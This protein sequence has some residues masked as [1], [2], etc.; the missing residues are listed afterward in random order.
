MLARIRQPLLI[1]VALSLLG[2]V[3]A[4]SQVA[5]AETVNFDPY[6][7]TW[8]RTDK[9]VSDSVVSRTWM[10]G[11]QATAYLT[12]EPYADSP[13]GERTVVYFD[14]SRMEVT[15]PYGDRSDPW[16]VTNGLLVVELVSGRL[17]LGHEQFEQHDP[18]QVNV[19]GDGA[20]PTG[21]TYAS[22]SG[23]VAPVSEAPPEVLTQTI[24][25]AGQVGSDSHYARY[26]VGTSQYVPE[27]GH[28]V[29]T[30]FWQFMNSSGIVWNVDALVTEA[31]FLNPFYATGYPITE[32]YWT[33]VR[34]AG[35]YRDVLV[36]CFE[37]RC[38]TYTP[39][40]PDGWQ[41]E[42]GNVGLHYYIWRYGEDPPR[43]VG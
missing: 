17:Q 6:Q 4:L 31:L 22:F 24:D 42:A 16:F 5:D 2:S 34:I 10:W 7:R 39:D 37:R 29:A 1:V 32:A 3:L 23:L 36:Q 27:T 19:A 25:R 9:P 35:E 20:D 41:V 30:P 15:D 12:T 26:G 33:N 18:A 11:P 21:P 13:D 40:N 43:P 8:A 38:L 28:W 14:K